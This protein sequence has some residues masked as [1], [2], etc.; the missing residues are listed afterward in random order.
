MQLTIR[1]NSGGLQDRFDLVIGTLGRFD[2]PVSGPTGGPALSLWDR[3]ARNWTR[4]R[5]RM[6]ASLG[7]DT[8]SPWPT[9]QQT[10]EREFYAHW[11]RA[12]LGTS[13]Y[14][15]EL[16]W[17]ETDRVFRSFCEP[18]NRYYV[19]NR[20]P[21]TIELGSSLPYA[22]KHDQGVGRAPKSLGGHPI[23]RRPLTRLGRWLVNEW[24]RDAVDYAVD[25]GAQIGAPLTGSQAR[26]LPLRGM[27]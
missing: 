19:D 9:Y 6:F 15:T 17:P 7:R 20:T 12:V 14:A 10:A 23:P 26:M 5:V 2:R 25:V 8:E 4:S 21:T 18:S 16:R 13:R 11:K 22:Y 24:E 3:M 27:A 1:S